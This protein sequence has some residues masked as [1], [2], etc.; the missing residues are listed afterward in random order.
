[1]AGDWMHA[2]G[3]MGSFTK[4]AI[5]KAPGVWNSVKG[6]VG[7]GGSAPASYTPDAGNFQ[8]G[9]GNGIDAS[10]NVVGLT[11]EQRDAQLKQRL[12]AIQAEKNAALAGL[13]PNSPE[14]AA[15]A[16]P[17]NEQSNAATEQAGRVQVVSDNFGA[18]RTR[19][20]VGKQAGVDALTKDAYG[21]A[22]PTQA[23]PGSIDFQVSDG[24]GYL[25]GADAASKQQQQSALGGLQSQ[26][27][28][29][30]NFAG[31]PEGPSAAQAQ[32]QAGTDMAARQQYGMARSQPG[33]GGSALRQAAFNAAG[34][35]G[36]AANTAATLRATE[37][38][39]YKARQLA[40]LNAAMGGAGTVSAATSQ[41]RGQDQG[42][43]ATRAGQANSDATAENAFNQ[44]QQQVEFNVGANNLG[45]ATQARGQNDAM[46]LGTI[47]AS[48]AYD[49]N[50]DDLAGSNTQ[51]G[52]NYE[53]AKAQGAGQGAQSYNAQ[54]DRD[55]ATTNAIIGG[56]SAAA[57]YAA[58]KSDARSKKD[59]QH[60]ERSLASSLG[61]L[62]TLGNAPG[63]SYRY[64]DPSEPGAA[65]GRQV[66]SM[67]QDLERGPRG[68][69]VVSNTPHGKMVDN[70]A[71]VKM[72]PGAL[73]ELN[74]KVAA[75][76]KAL[77]RRA[78]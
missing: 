66:S 71:I 38:S 45:A 64:K 50:R 12:E 34:I 40:A 10:G 53:A 39:D 44:N 49:A 5:D 31:T 59:I 4:M 69:E 54:L 36:N 62:D 22:A 30:N 29:L 65:P 6:A 33:G 28:A 76:E 27:T 43:A 11:A 25:E 7:G 32:L 24:Q 17:F 58:T 20:L 55:Q 21:R 67:A 41:A 77:G 23:M 16:Q 18:Q 1:M 61:E 14:Y 72:T 78:A 8:Y 74:Q 19:E 68:S 3:P 37:T 13:D 75:L 73:T 47:Q 15:A 46:T 70:D 63:Y 48:Q 52:N 51:Q 9:L 26:V 2:L 42:F 35:S 56:A 60:T 57:G